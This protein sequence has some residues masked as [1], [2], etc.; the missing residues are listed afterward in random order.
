MIHF[1]YEA[2][3]AQ[4]IV[5]MIYNIFAALV[6]LMIFINEVNKDTKKK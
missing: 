2:L 5:W 1:A 3:N 6:G 4:N